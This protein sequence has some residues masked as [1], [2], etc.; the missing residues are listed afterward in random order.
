MKYE[1]EILLYNNNDS[2]CDK[3]AIFAY[4]FISPL[5]LK[6]SFNNGKYYFDEEFKRNVFHHI[7]NTLKVKY[8]FPEGI[9][10]KNLGILTKIGKDKNDIKI[11]NE[12]IGYMNIVTKEKIN[13][14]KFILTLKFPIFNFEINCQKS[15][16]PDL[17]IFDE[18][19]IIFEKK[20][21]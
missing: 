10:S 19:N 1:F 15:E 8:S 4:T 16:H 20:N 17:V 6:F 13:N 14:Y 7:T 3:C 9:C 11:D 5:F 12:I 18:Q 21:L 2:Q